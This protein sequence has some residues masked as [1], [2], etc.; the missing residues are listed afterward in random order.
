[1]QNGLPYAPHLNSLE[2]SQNG[3]S[4]PVAQRDGKNSSSC[5]SQVLTLQQARVTLPRSSIALA[6]C[7]IRVHPREPPTS[8]HGI[9]VKYGLVDNVSFALGL[10]LF[11]E[12]LFVFRARRFVLRY[13]DGTGAAMSLAVGVRVIAVPKPIGTVVLFCFL[14]AMLHSEV[15]GTL[16]G[17]YC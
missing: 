5:S 8:K 15:I 4:V 17:Y 2:I 9:T 3:V 10:V 11:C 13:C 6:R 7:S 1:M 14:L 16:D 12:N